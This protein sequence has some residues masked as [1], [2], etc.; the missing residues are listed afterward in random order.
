MEGWGKLNPQLHIW[1]I[2]YMIRKELGGY[3]PEEY[4]KQQFFI[5]LYS[6]NANQQ[7]KKSR[8]ERLKGM[9]R[10]KGK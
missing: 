5:S 9:V 7:E 8:M 2:E 1:R 10:R 3:F 4:D 6:A